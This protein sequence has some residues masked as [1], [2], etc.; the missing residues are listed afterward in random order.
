MLH[1]GEIDPDYSS[2]HHLLGLNMMVSIILLLLRGPSPQSESPFPDPESTT[3]HSLPPFTLAGHHSYLPPPYPPLCPRS[4]SC[5]VVH[6]CC[7]AVAE[8]EGE[9]ASNAA[10]EPSVVTQ[11]HTP[12]C[13]PLSISEE[14]T[15]QQLTSFT[16]M[17]GSPC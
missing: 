10:L 5:I 16:N 6:P 3:A 1:I 12:S 14:W 8:G 7:A 11:P 2:H 13:P 9:F 4:T 15:G 17:C